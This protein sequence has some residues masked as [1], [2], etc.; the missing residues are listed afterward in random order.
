[1]RSCSSVEHRGVSDE[2]VVM[3]PL[4]SHDGLFKAAP[5]LA[6]LTAGSDA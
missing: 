6:L 4:V 2:S 3:A 1:V 5:R